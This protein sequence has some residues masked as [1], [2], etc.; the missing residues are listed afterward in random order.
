MARHDVKILTVGKQGV[1][2]IQTF[3]QL[4]ILKA[5]VDREFDLAF[6]LQRKWVVNAEQAEW[7]CLLLGVELSLAVHPGHVA[8]I[9]RFH[10][11]VDAACIAA[12][13]TR[14]NPHHKAAGLD[15]HIEVK[16]RVVCGDGRV[17]V[18]HA[19]LDELACNPKGTRHI[20][21]LHAVVQRVLLG[22]D[23]LELLQERRKCGLT[24]TK[25]SLG[26][27]L[28]IFYK[29]F[30]LVHGLQHRDDQVVVSGQHGDTEQAL[31]G[32]AMKVL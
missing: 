3:H 27:S 19:L 20:A 26:K 25:D 5:F 18:V 21:A 7:I 31:D 29:N 1:V 2:F 4:G 24:L 13:V 28:V 16:I 32:V 30:I 22:S 14:S 10:L 6:S 17:A 12:V 23:N 11:D 8:D 15:A 9:V